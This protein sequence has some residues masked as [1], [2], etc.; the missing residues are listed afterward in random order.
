MPFEHS[1]GL[2]TGGEVKKPKMYEVVF[3]NDD[4]TPMDF[5]V[6]VLQLVFNKGKAEA[7]QIMMQVHKSDRAVVGVYTRDIA[8]T[9]AI[10]AVDMARKAGYPLKVEAVSQ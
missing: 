10:T 3:Y 2:K 1:T 9:K 7:Y 8:R 6:D 4:F 5:V